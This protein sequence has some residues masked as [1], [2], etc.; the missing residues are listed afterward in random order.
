MHGLLRHVCLLRWLAREVTGAPWNS[1]GRGGGLLADIAVPHPSGHVHG[2]TRL[3]GASRPLLTGAHREP[4][5]H[6]EPGRVG[7]GGLLAS[8]PPIS[9]KTKPPWRRLAPRDERR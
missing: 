9:G 8:N 5:P 1:A 2:Y 7:R 4:A 3:G 6:G